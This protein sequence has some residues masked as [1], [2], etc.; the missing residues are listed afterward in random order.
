MMLRYLP[1][2][3]SINLQAL[4]YRIMTLFR[5]FRTILVVLIAFVVLAPMLI[6]AQY[7]SLEVDEKDGIPV[8]VKHLPEWQSV[9][10]QAKLTNSVGDLKAVLG[11]SP[12]LGVI[13]MNAGAEAVTAS[14]PA[15]RLVLIEHHTPQFASSNDAAINAKLAETGDKSIVYKRIGNYNALVFDVAD[16]AAAEALLGQIKYQKSVHWL[17]EDPFFVSRVERYMIGTTGD[18][19]V[20]TALF[21]VMCLAGA[22]AVGLLGGYVYFSKR[23]Q[24]RLT[25]TSFSDAGGLTRLNLDQLTE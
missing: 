15:G 19:L 1:R 14:Y 23:E 8:I 3:N 20:S 2:H 21:I 18:V 16:P 25:R 11:D 9:K 13:E 7:K 12:V 10:D 24:R 17:G 22:I 5:P 6:H 4:P